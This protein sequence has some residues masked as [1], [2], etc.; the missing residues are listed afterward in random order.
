MAVQ[1]NA[2]RQH[3]VADWLGYDEEGLPIKPEEGDY[4]RLARHVITQADDSQ[5]NTVEE[6]DYAGD[7]TPTTEVESYT[8]RWNSSGYYNAEDKA[9]AL[10]VSKKRAIGD[11]KKGWH[12][13]IYPNGMVVEGPVTFSAIRA[14]SGDAT[15]REEFAVTINHDTIPEEIPPVVPGG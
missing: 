3:F 6:G 14:G 8:E 5:D 4:E 7:G 2:K 11:A 9:Q 15:A 10:I 12:K 1:K 13:I